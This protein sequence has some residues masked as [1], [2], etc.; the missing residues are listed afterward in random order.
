MDPC[1]C[2][3]EYLVLLNLQNSDFISTSRPISGQIL[4]FV[5]LMAEQRQR[6]WACVGG[7]FPSGDTCSAT[8]APSICRVQV[9]KHSHRPVGNKASPASESHC[10]NWARGW[11]FCSLNILIAWIWNQQ[12]QCFR[13][14]GASK[15]MKS[16]CRCGNVLARLAASSNLV[17][18]QCSPSLLLHLVVSPRAARLF[19]SHRPNTDFEGK[20]HRVDQKRSCPDLRVLISSS[21]DGIQQT[22]LEVSCPCL[23]VETHSAW[24]DKT[25]SWST[26]PE[27]WCSL[28]R[29]HR[30]PPYWGSDPSHDRVCPSRFKSR[31][32]ERFSLFA[33]IKSN[34]DKHSECHCEPGGMWA[35]DKGVRN[36]TN[37]RGKETPKH[38]SSCVCCRTVT[39]FLR[40]LF[41]LNGLIQSVIPCKVLTC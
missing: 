22:V 35:C 34:K 36:R 16:A 31:A 39:E 38:R 27:L 14:C 32:A 5:R 1:S 15:K 33:Q 41:Y 3:E 40:D 21:F 13:P 8:E 24:T 20:W 19:S 10:E 25:N 6:D 11:M 30:S 28:W 29:T 18:W 12:Q 2:L 17:Q 7:L 26:R 9:M 4:K 23:L 37:L